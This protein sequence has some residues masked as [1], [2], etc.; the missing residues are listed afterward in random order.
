MSVHK[1]KNTNTW[2]VK[3]QNH[4]K[5]GFRYKKEAMAYEA[6][7]LMKEKNGEGAVM[8]FTVIDEYLANKKTEIQYT[9][10]VKYEENI[11]LILKKIFPNKP[12]NEIVYADCEKCRMELQKMEYATSMKNRCITNLKEIFEY[13][14]LRKY[15][16]TNPA[17]R[18][19]AFKMT[20]EEVIAKKQRESNVWSY[21]EFVRF[22]EHVDGLGHQALYF[23]LFNTGMRLGEALALTW[24]DFENKRLHI[25]KSCTKKTQKGYYEIKMPKSVSSIRTV[26]I[27]DTLNEFL[28][29]YKKEEMKAADFSEE[30]FMF[31]G[32]RPFPESCVQQ[33]KNSAIRKSGVK[34]IRI[35]DFRH[36][37]ATILINNG[38]N[39]VAVSKRLGHSDIN[40]TLK[41]YT[42]LLEER[43]TEITNL[44]NNSSQSVKLMSK[45]V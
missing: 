32:K 4:T 18:I 20:N 43:N 33:R 21:E 19:K 30:Q 45:K 13:A 1:D 31:G 3:Y 17:A 27:D 14:I 12:V 44:L 6:Q 36:S 38:M 40:I 7:M 34:Y 16:E 35:H 24:R 2:Y 15:I 37:H 25:T 23:T 42:H 22:L 11:R 28:L 29:N 26:D 41:V 5:R 8:F 39:I 10:Y 9:S